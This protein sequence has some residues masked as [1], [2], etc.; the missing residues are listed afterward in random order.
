MKENFSLSDINPAEKLKEI[1]KKL[2]LWILQIIVVG[3][4]VSI[5]L[6]KCGLM[7]ESSIKNYIKY[8]LIGSAVLYS[9]TF[10]YFVYLCRN[11]KTDYTEI[12]KLSIL[13]PSVIL[14]HIA[15]LLSSTFIQVIPEVGLII[16][17]LIWSSFGIVLTSGILYSV[18]FGIAELKAKC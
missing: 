1:G 17:G 18:G 8:L 6:N 4:I 2:L 9:L 7:D 16:Y 14:V 10:A 12:A 15:I 3:V 5:V 11:G 13:G